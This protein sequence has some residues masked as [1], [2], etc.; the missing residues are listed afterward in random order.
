MPK[1]MRA[2][3]PSAHSHALE[4]AGLALQRQQPQ[5]AER[6]CAAVLKA[7]RGNLVALQILAAA[8]LQ[9]DRPQEAVELLRRAARRSQQPAIETLLARALTA[10]G[11]RDE[12]LEQLR[13]AVTRRPVYA[14]AFLDLGVGLGEAGRCREGIA[15]LDQGLALAPDADG[16]RV[17]LGHLRL[18][19]GECAEARQA[20]QDVRGRA[21]G[22]HDAMVGLA[23]TLALQG[24]YAGAADLYRAALAIRPDD[25]LTR[26]ALGKCLL[27]MGERE[28][29]E[30]AIRAAGRG[31]PALAG[32][33]LTALASTPH[34]RVFMR[35]S[36]A[37]RFLGGAA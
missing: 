23:K 27:E 8:L 29:G 10:A 21:P 35:P 31:S 18:K 33:A 28:A 25:P 3:R 34:G 1:P 9:Q 7:D 11:L 12:A 19:R 30:A 36:A 4:E 24:D 16:L 32:L 15:V 26:I 5:T 37:A 22:R 14:L 17:A 13:L 2:A 20:F 6:L